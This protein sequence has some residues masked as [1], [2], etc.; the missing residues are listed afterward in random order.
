[1]R[2]VHN[3]LKSQKL[4]K[5]DLEYNEISNTIHSIKITGDFFLYPEDSLDKLETN[6]I[7]TKLEKNSLIQKIRESLDDS[8]VFGFDS[9]SLTKAILGCL[10]H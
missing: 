8:Q 5:I 3:V 1:M 2:K 10:I 9:E 4:I 7:D 6:L